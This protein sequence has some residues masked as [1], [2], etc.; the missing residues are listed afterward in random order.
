MQEF[1]THPG[2]FTFDIFYP[3]CIVRWLTVESC[4]HAMW[5]RPE[6]LFILCSSAAHHQ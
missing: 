1:V 2:L 4:N 6:R 3:L 5:M